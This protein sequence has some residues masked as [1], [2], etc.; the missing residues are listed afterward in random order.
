MADADSHNPAE[1]V[2]I[3]TPAL[4]ED[5]LRATFHDHDRRLVIEE[6]AGIQVLATETQNLV[7]RRPAVRA[8]LMIEF[9]QLRRGGARGGFLFGFG[10]DH[11]SLQMLPS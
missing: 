1:R 11:F 4:V 6:D 7:E 9:W 3:T 5:I 8:R 2:E 10:S